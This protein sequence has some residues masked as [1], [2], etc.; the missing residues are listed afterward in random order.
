MAEPIGALRVDLSANA[1]QFE[2]DMGRAKRAVSS[3]TKSMQSSMASFRTG[4]GKA[5]KGLFSL[6]A[7]AFAAAGVVGMALLVKR[8]IEAADVIGK[9]A[10]KIGIGIEALQEFRFAAELAGVSTRTFDMGLQRFSRRFAEAAQGTGELLTVINQY[11]I[12]TR[13]ADGSTRSLEDALSDY[14]DVIANASTD[15]ER[16][17]LAFKAFDSEGAA[18]VNLFRK[19]SNGIAQM[20]QEARDLGVV[21]DAS[22]VRE[23]EKANDQ[24]TR[25]GTIL[26]TNLT[27]ALI[28]MAPQIIALGDSFI[29]NIGP[30]AEWLT[31]TLPAGTANA[32]ELERRI[33]VLNDTMARLSSAPAISMEFG[34]LD[35]SRRHRRGMKYKRK[36]MRLKSYLSS[37]NVKR[38]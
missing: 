14:A 29:K 19:G 1:A 7:A 13:N 22:M 24:L 23:A 2:K 11:G 17:R 38:R 5:V 18:L 30:F 37:V 33:G 4:L 8:S 6:K 27:R 9:T 25:M 26:S 34:L 21:L 36:S 31:E 32:A 15:Q 28:T 16:L 20:R 12:A 35:G 3:S 10:D